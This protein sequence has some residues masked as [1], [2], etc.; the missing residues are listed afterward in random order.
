MPPE[1]KRER[2]LAL[3]GLGLFFAGFVSG[4]VFGLW[5]PV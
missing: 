3:I 1:Q 4:W 2:T 5:W